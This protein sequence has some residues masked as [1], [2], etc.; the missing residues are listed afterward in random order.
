MTKILEQ[1]RERSEAQQHVER[2]RR[3]VSRRIGVGEMQQRVER[4]REDYGWEGTELLPEAL[5]DESPVQDFLEHSY[6]EREKN[7]DPQRS[8]GVEIHTPCPE[9]DHCR[10]RKAHK[11]YPDGDTHEKM[12][13][14][15]E[16][17]KIER[18]PD[19][20][21]ERVSEDETEDEESR[22]GR[23]NDN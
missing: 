22:K 13:E 10:H 16:E 21:L 11:D 3:E 6:P 1:A 5:E 7:G 8:C 18:A 17:G 23:V 14:D 2:P 12:G 4:A 9:Y 20:R 19:V 15:G